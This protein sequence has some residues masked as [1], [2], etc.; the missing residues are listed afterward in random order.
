MENNS[1]SNFENYWIQIIYFNTLKKY[2]L[3]IIP[4]FK[5]IAST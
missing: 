4:L 3:N 5:L 2:Y 1:V